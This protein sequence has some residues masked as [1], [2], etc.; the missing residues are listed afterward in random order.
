MD[1]PV[2]DLDKRHWTAH[3]RGLTAIGTWF[4]QDERIE[5]GL[6]R[7]GQWRPAMV[8]CRTGTETRHDAAKC[9]IPMERAWLWAP[10]TGDAD[11][12]S[13]IIPRFLD[14]LGLDPMSKADNDRLISIVLDHL[15]DLL[16]IPPYP[17]PEPKPEPVMT[18]RFADSTGRKIEAEI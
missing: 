4:R 9:I 14:A 15:G 1:E 13:M 17:F 2:L 11:A 3:A 18:I 10:E 7:R 8:I 5:D 12:C 6:V 16:S